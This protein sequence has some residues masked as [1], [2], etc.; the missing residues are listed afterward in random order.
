MQAKPFQK[1]T[2]RAE[3]PMAG[4]LPKEIVGLMLRI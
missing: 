3:A 2:L 1:Y 4:S